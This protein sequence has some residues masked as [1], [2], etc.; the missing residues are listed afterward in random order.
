MQSRLDDVRNN[1]CLAQCAKSLQPVKPFNQ[2]IGAPIRPNL[3]W[4][5]LAMLNYVLGDHL[6]FACVQRSRTLDRD[7][8]A[9]NRDTYLF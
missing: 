7:A 1:H 5:G 8:D 4:S 3:N 9:G 6:K 2:D